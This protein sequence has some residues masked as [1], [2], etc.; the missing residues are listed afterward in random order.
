MRRVTALGQPPMATA[1]LLER[2][3]PD[4]VEVLFDVAPGITL[5]AICAPPRAA[6]VGSQSRSDRRPN[7][8]LEQID[9]YLPGP[10][11]RDEA[12]RRRLS[13]RRNRRFLL[14]SLGRS[15]SP[16]PILLCPGPVLL[17]PYVMRAVRN[18]NIGHRE[19]EFSTLLLES[20][21]MLRAI[22]GIG[23]AESSYQ[24]ALITGSGT[25]ANEAVLASIGR[26]GPILVLTNG[27]FG[28]RLLATARQHNPDVS[29]LRC[30]WQQGIRLDQVEAE[31]RRRHFHLVVVVHHETSTGMLNPIAAIAELAHRYGA[32]IAVDAI[33]S[34]GAEVIAVE[35]WDI[36]VMTGT[37]GKALSAMPGVGIVVVKT[38]VLEQS[39]SVSGG[40]RYLSLHAH[41]RS[42]RDQAQT[43]NTPAV[44][45]FVS[46]H[47]ALREHSR[48]GE[49]AVRAVINSRAAYV[50]NQLTRMGLEYADYGEATSNVLTC[51]SLPKDLSFETLT[52]HLKSKGI[53]IYNGKGSLAGKIFQIAHIGALRNNDSRDALGHVRA[54]MRQAV[55]ITGQS[56]PIPVERQPRGVS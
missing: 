19:P 11:R 14:S 56:R 6:A 34:I 38:S 12:F 20:S 42:M 2:P 35:E 15:R 22:V 26:R 18:T 54:A 33:S 31:L 55:S 1:D 44:H 27:E 24:V 53:I 8:S 41:C 13:G 3:M 45:V 28:E 23:R 47:A 50:R 52:S 9:S 16:R 5:E 48:S 37:S 49:A 43:P 40:P 39:A 46:L 10:G 4:A 17:S 29:E 30:A 36:D 7:S 51:V 25:A 32:L 21:A